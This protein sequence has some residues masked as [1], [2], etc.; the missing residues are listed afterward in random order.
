[1]ELIARHCRGKST[2][3]GHEIRVDEHGDELIIWYLHWGK[4]RGVDGH[5][6]LGIARVRRHGDEIALGL[7]EGT[8]QAPHKTQTFGSISEACVALDNLI[9]SR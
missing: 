5:H 2:G 8:E 9:A 1:M 4:Y 7:L 6:H 3:S